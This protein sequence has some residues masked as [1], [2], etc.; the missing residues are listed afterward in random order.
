MSRYTEFTLVF[1]GDIRE[2]PNP[3]A[4]ETPFGVPVMSGVFNAFD[5]AE[6]LESKLEEALDLLR[7]LPLPEADSGWAKGLLSY[8]ECQRFRRLRQRTE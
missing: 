4:T 6:E 2:F 3:H 1:E 7:L 5:K 8:A